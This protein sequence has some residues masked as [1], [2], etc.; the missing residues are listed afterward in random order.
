MIKTNEEL[1]REDLMAGKIW[2]LIISFYDIWHHAPQE[3]KDRIALMSNAELEKF[4]ND[5]EHSWGKGFDWGFNSSSDVIFRTV[6]ENSEWTELDE[7]EDE[8]DDEY[9]EKTWREKS[10]MKLNRKEENK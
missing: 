6:A 5:N 7:E 3:F 1:E 10:G 9:Y 8:P 2:S 4:I